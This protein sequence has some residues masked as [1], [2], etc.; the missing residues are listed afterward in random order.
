[1]TKAAPSKLPPPPRLHVLLAREAPLG[2]IIRRGPHRYSCT[3]LWDRGND[4]F[5]LGQWVK[6]RLYPE[7]CDLSPNGQHFIYFAL[8]GYRHSESR[9]SYTAVSR[10]PYLK[11]LSFYPRGDTWGGGGLFINNSSFYAEEPLNSNTQ[12]S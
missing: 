11:A 10:A 8:D 12:E 4:T 6:A 9:G 3:L 1:M 5:Q 2:L 7:R